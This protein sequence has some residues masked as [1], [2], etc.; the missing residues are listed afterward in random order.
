MNDDPQDI[1]SLLK[2]FRKKPLFD[3]EAIDSPRAFTRSDI[4]QLIPHR[5]PFLLLDAITGFDAPACRIAGRRFVD[6][7]DPVFRGHF[8]EFPVYP[9]V[10]QL[11]MLGQIGSA[12]SA[13][14]EE[15][16]GIVT[17]SRRP[18]FI[19]AIKVLGSLFIEPLLPNNDVTIIGERIEWD[20]TLARFIGQTVV[21]RTV[22][23]VAAGEL[24]VAQP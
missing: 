7:A 9:G 14:L 13:L 17:S 15:P 5:E 8:P 24:L 19:R 21:G 6:A 3:L 20:G 2:R 23:T 10:L 4:E 16:V 22:C 1:Q 11:E 12:L 18:P